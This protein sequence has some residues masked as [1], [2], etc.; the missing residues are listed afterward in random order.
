M[1]RPP[2][3]NPVVSP[4]HV[5]IY[6]GRIKPDVMAY[7]KDVTGSKITAGCRSLSGTSVASP[8]V[9]GAVCLLAST[10][11][12]ERRWVSKHL[13]AAPGQRAWLCK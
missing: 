7:A 8:V 2:W 5:L 3:L 4:T 13:N 12:E 10:V 9:A 1:R 11:P 6:A